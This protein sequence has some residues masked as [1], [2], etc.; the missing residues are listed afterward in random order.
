MRGIKTRQ[1]RVSLGVAEIVDCDDLDVIFLAA[2]VVGTKNIAANAAVAINCNADSHGF[3]L[4]S[5]IQQIQ[6]TLV[7]YYSI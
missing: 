4:K 2:F 6:N 5:K 7:K 1:V 3:L